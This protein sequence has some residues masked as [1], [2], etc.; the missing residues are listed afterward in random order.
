MKIRKVGLVLLGF[1]SI[2][3]II[4]TGCDSN[5]AIIPEDIITNVVNLDKE[6]KMF[7]GESKMDTYEN[8]RKVST[9]NLREW[10]LPGNKVRREVVSDLGNGKFDKAIMTCDG[11]KMILYSNNVYMQSTNIMKENWI[12]SKSPK[13]SAMDEMANITKTHTIEIK[14]EDVVNNRN[15]YHLYA[16]PKNPNKRGILAGKIDYWIDKDNWFIVKCESNNGNIRIV[17]EYLNVN[18]HPKINNNMFTQEI[19]KGVKV[20]NLDEKDINKSITVTEA[21]KK[22]GKEILIYKGMDYNLDKICY[23]E[24]SSN[25]GN[26][27]NQIYVD[28][29]GIEVFNI[30]VTKAIRDTDKEKETKLVIA[31]KVKVRGVDGEILEANNFKSVLWEEDGT[32][33][34]IFSNTANFT[35]DDC[36]KIAEQLVKSK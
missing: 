7:Y 35:L 20:E 10:S 18:F 26:E 27:I 31:E 2:S 14:G 16:K 5:S 29:R 33:Y 30:S 28:N 23:I 11:K 19:P 4:F 12:M 21:S 34:S 9:L 13:K 17:S 15:T 32:N 8:G 25:T 36:K 1:I 6:N 22:I 3:S 24:G